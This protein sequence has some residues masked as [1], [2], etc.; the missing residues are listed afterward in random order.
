VDGGLEQVSVTGGS[1]PVWARSGAELFFV[2]PDRRMNVARV[3][4]ETGFRVVQRQVLFTL[5]PE[6]IGYSIGDG[7]DDFYDV[8]PGDE[9][10]LMGRLVTGDGAQRDARPRLILVQNWTEEL[11]RRVP[12]H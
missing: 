12:A 2:D 3:E 5:T 7:G 8:A 11:E 4:T 10:F 9:R 6:L 1:N